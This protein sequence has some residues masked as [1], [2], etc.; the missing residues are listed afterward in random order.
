[1]SL[2][3]QA[4]APKV[5]LI[6]VGRLTNAVSENLIHRNLS[7]TTILPTLAPAIVWSPGKGTKHMV[8]ILEGQSFKFKLLIERKKKT[9]PVRV[10]LSYLI[11][12][13]KA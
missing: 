5:R 1:M 3:I 9:C 8:P 7:I 2:H 11:S 13:R 12:I 4:R 6:K 10:V